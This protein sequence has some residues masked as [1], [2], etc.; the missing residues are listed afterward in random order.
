MDEAKGR[1]SADGAPPGFLYDYGT[2]YDMVRR[3]KG[4]VVTVTLDPKT[5]GHSIRV[6]TG[7]DAYS[8]PVADADF[9][10][11]AA[12]LGPRLQR[13]GLLP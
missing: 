12:R 1:S 4:V 11:A 9:D 6:S 2:L 10:G 8:E 3:R 7:S 13:L 5:P